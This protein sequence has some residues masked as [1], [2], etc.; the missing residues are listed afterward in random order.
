MDLLKSMEKYKQKLSGNQ[1][2]SREFLVRV[3]IYTEKGK[4]VVEFFYNPGS[5]FWGVGFSIVGLAA[6]IGGLWM[7]K[8]KIHHDPD[9]DDEAR[10]RS[11]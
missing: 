7:E 1:K 2:A 6:L 4:H 9:L 10:T 3:G 5:F 11:S 8:M